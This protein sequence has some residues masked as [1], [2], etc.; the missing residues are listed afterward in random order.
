MLVRW[1]GNIDIIARVLFGIVWFDDAKRF[2]FF[3]CDS[4]A[5]FSLCCAAAEMKL[6]ISISILSPVPY[7]SPKHCRCRTTRLG[8]P[9]LILYSGHAPNQALTPYAPSLHRHTA[10]GLRARLETWPHHRAVLFSR[11]QTV[12]SGQWARAFRFTRPS[13]SLRII[14]TRT[15]LRTAMSAG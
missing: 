1:L 2:Y 12:R 8:A 4:R 7:P 14:L 11:I 3:A 10:C 5:F 6:K 13:R 15:P 9:N